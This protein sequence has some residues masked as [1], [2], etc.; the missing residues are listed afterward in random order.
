M[1]CPS[2]AGKI[3]LILCCYD[4]SS[5]PP[6]G[7][8]IHPC[9]VNNATGDVL[10][11]RT[12]DRRSHILSDREKEVL[13]LIREGKPSKQIASLLGISVHTVNRHRQNIIE[14]LS[15]GNTVEA[16]MAATLMKLL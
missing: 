6:S 10:A 1:L 5:S 11:V 14:K 7:G 4:L 2:P 13:G 3:W 8:G 9:I 12:A 16:I 15:V